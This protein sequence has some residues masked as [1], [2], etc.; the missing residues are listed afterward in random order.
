MNVSLRTVFLMAFFC[1]TQ[2]Y[3]SIV[4]IQSF[5]DIYL[6]V[7][8]DTL[9]VFDVDEVL[10]T[11]K[12][13]ILRPCGSHFCP[14]SWKNIDQK[15]YIFLI[16]IMFNESQP[17]LV[18]PSAPWFIKKLQAKGAKTMALTAA[19]T[20]KFGVIENA[21]DWRL[22]I[23]KQF[24]VDFSH[25]FP[26][27]PLIYFDQV[28]KESDYLLFKKGILF[29]GDEK[30]TKGDLLIQFLEKMQYKPK[31][32]IFFDDKMSHLISVET[33]LNETEISFQ[34]YQYKGA[35]Q[36]PQEFDEQIAEM[37]F[38]YLRKNRK[39]ISDSELKK[40]NQMFLNNF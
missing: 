14:T 35:E 27:S 2:I 26:E 5:K 38:E 18:E 37:Q 30:N 23:L 13:M 6:E 40:E 36:L 21:E 15:E 16:S 12:D 33:A 7:D 31:K 10:I 28:T 19:R 24:D 39:W 4:S 3:S 29:L 20:G 1:L 11:C 9:V 34:G 17:M 25:A 8:Q 22:K 32:V